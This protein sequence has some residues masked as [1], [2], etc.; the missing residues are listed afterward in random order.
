[1]VSLFVGPEPK[2]FVAHKS[3]LSKSSQRFRASLSG[4]WVE[5]DTNEIHLPEEDPELFVCYVDF[6]Y[7]KT[8]HV[9]QSNVYAEL[10]E[11]LFRTVRLHAMALRLM[12][13]KYETH[14]INAIIALINPED[15]AMIVCLPSS[16]SVNHVWTEEPETS[17]VRQLFVDA[18]AHHGYGLIV[19]QLTVF[20]LP[21]EFLIE[22]LRA[23]ATTRPLPE[24]ESPLIKSN[25]CLYHSH[26][27]GA[28]C[29]I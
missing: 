23:M 29:V 24:R 11:E 18:W 13:D 16:Q 26:A 6:L 9:V 20:D 8:V 2:L 17:K 12:D 28:P 7:R 15:N 1:M 21:K 5:N 22:V 27:L 10:D 25:A 3:V 14:L 4:L 19:Y